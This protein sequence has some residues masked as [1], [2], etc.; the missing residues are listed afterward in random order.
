M[1]RLTRKEQGEATRARLLEAGLE[2]FTKGGIVSTK[3]TEIAAAAGVSVGTLYLH[4]GDKM[5][6]LEAVLLKM[7]ASMASQLD[8]LW[9]RR[10]EGEEVPFQDMAERLLDVVEATPERV[11]LFLSPEVQA[12]EVGQRFMDQLIHEQEL[13]LRQAR[14]ARI[15]RSDLDPALA[16]RALMG[17]FVGVLG[18]WS[19]HPK[20]VDRAQ[21][22]SVLEAMFGACGKYHPR[23]SP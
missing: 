16:A 10:L 7:L 14:D 6:L 18:W 15:A 8:E 17:S 23:R 9:S 2:L 19:L 12:T 5:G 21:V 1:S 20:S 4:Y 11:R 22:I 3:A 13:R